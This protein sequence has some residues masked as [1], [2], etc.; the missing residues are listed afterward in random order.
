MPSER[1]SAKL[2]RAEVARIVR[3]IARA[4]R[5]HRGE[6]GVHVEAR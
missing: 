6:I 2:D 4:E 1:R 3:A 5:G